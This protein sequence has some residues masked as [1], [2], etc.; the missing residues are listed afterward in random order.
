MNTKFIT[1]ILLVIE[2]IIGSTGLILGAL[3]SNDVF[4]CKDYTSSIDLTDLNDQTC[5]IIAYIIFGA[6]IIFIL[7][8]ILVTILF[9]IYYDQTEEEEN[10]HILNIENPEDR[11]DGLSDPNDP[12]DQVYQN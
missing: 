7:S 4:I 6:S 2:L 3:M 12:F 5:E 8:S 9:Y 1:I 11:F 10:I